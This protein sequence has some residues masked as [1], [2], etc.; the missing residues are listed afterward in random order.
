MPRLHEPGRL[1]QNSMRVVVTRLRGMNL[2]A[3][4][5]QMRIWL[6]HN[7]TEPAFFESVTLPNHEI[8]FLIQ[9]SSASD[10]SAFAKDF[11][12]KVLSVPDEVA[13]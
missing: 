1:E 7:Q 4:M 9:F 8:R 3:A 5:S 6:D 10:A 12:G 11:D 13:A 2:G